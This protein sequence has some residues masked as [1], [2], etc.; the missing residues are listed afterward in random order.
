MI[1]VLLNLP[2]PIPELQHTLLHLKCCEARSAP[3]FL[4]LQLFSFGLVV[5]SIKELGVLQ[6]FSNKFNVGICTPSYWGK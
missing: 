3:Q 6:K 2:N 1:E 5:E 4:L